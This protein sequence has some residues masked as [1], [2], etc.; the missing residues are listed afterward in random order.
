MCG[1][2]LP[3]GALSDGFEWVVGHWSRAAATTFAAAPA[4]ALQTTFFQTLLTCPCFNFL[5]LRHQQAP[6][7]LD[8]AAGVIVPDQGPFAHT[9]THC[10]VGKIAGSQR[11][12]IARM[13]GLHRQ[14]AP[15]SAMSCSATKAC[16]VAWQA[17]STVRRA[18]CSMS[19]CVQVMAHVT[20]VERRKIAVHC[21]AGLGRTG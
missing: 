7:S 21:H 20:G 1:Q 17:R 12:A 14:G 5:G 6:S 8:C 10:S 13:P 18:C 9:Y 16:V 4:S 11:A 2:T 19:V 3:G 15:P